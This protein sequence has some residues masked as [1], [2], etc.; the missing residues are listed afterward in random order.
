MMPNYYP[1]GGVMIATEAGTIYAEL[2]ADDEPQWAERQAALID[3]VER[4][5]LRRGLDQRKDRY[6]VIDR[7]RTVLAGGL[8][9]DLRERYRGPSDET[10]PSVRRTEFDEAED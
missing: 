2:T 10:K 7:R 6:R 1:G 3:T 4:E 8:I 9:S 5:L